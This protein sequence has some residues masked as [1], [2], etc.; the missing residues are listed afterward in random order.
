MPN[1]KP[2]D[3]PITDIVH[4]GREVYGEE[5]DDLVREIVALL[6]AACS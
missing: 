3:N 4:W 5:I 6:P 1:G 2:G